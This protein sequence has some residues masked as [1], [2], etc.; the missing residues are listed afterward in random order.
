MADPFATDTPSRR[1]AQNEVLRKFYGELPPE[2]LTQAPVSSAEMI[3]GATGQA[4]G[5]IPFLPEPN[6]G[7]ADINTLL[8]AGRS[9]DKAILANVID[10]AISRGEITWRELSPEARSVYFK[11]DRV[12]TPLPVNP[13]ASTSAVRTL[14]T[15]GVPHALRPPYPE[16]HAPIDVHRPAR[17]HA[18]PISASYDALKELSPDEE[19]IVRT[20]KGHQQLKHKTRLDTANRVA[21]L[22]PDFSQGAGT[23]YKKELADHQI[24][25][26][27]HAANAREWLTGVS[28]LPIFKTIGAVGREVAKRP[29]TTVA[30]ALG[31]LPDPSELIALAAMAPYY[32]LHE[33][34]GRKDF[35]DQLDMVA[36]EHTAGQRPIFDAHQLSPMQQRDI[37]EFVL[38]ST[39]P[40]SAARLLLIDRKY[41]TPEALDMI[42]MDKGRPSDKPKAT[43]ATTERKSEVEPSSKFLIDKF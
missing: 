37:R 41:I 39:S 24:A 23:K 43:T 22:V 17:A 33:L 32:G 35:I 26:G 31:L 38:N 5:R 40:L 8:G 1:I 9:G 4:L 20:A 10:D 18:L 11:L 15:V 36:P 3:A 14:S 42:L 19:Y 25:I 6:V 30:S 21:E 13:E 16:D 29:I 27:R 12:A 7:P 2:E 28:N 34:G